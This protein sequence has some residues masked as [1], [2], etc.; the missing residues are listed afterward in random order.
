MHC[1][2]EIK[3]NNE[4]N[5][6]EPN[7]VRKARMSSISLYYL[8]VPPPLSHFLTFATL[9]YFVFIVLL[10]LCIDFAM[11]ITSLN[12]WFSNIRLWPWNE[13]M[14]HCQNL[15]LMMENTIEWEIPQYTRY[16]KGKQCCKKICFTLY[17]YTI[18]CVCL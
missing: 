18:V 4:I 14:G 3:K 17:M 7:T 1:K 13:K 2:Y 5:I 16:G 6:H 8:W 12:Q 11:Y 9:M 10:L 15:V